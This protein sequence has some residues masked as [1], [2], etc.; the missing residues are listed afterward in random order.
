MT[1]AERS[2]LGQLVAYADHYDPSLLFP[3]ARLEQ[4]TTL[5][6]SGDRLDRKS[7]RLNSSH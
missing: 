7:T 2:P 5:G 6:L 4:R 1:Q 3:V